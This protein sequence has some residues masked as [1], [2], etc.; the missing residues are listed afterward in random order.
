MPP[1]GSKPAEAETASMH[2]KAIADSNRFMVVSLL[3]FGMQDLLHQRRINQYPEGVGKVYGRQLIFA[4]TLHAF[5]HS[6]RK[7]IL[8]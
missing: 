4:R 1:V 8:S 2:V 5:L 3:G 6:R 7:V